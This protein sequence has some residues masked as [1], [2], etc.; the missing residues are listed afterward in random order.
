MKITRFTNIGLSL[1]VAA[2]A[3][4]AFSVPAKAETA[5]TV[6]KI[7]FGGRGESKTVDKVLVENLNTGSSVVLKGN[8]TLL[9]TSELSA[10]E[11]VKLDGEVSVDARGGY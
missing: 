3:G 9:L 11:S 8:Q 1:F 7:T 10:I 2:L 6:Y 4:I 5:P